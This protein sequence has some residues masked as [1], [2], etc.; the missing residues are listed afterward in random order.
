MARLNP[1]Y[2]KGLTNKQV[3]EQMAK[4]LNYTDVSVPTKS[5]KR[6]VS[7]N[8]FTLFNFL[9]FGLAAAIIA[10]GAYKNCLFIGT[11]IFNIIISI[12]QEIRA[13]QIVDK[14]SLISQS[15]V[16]VIRDG[17]HKDISREEMVQDD[18]VELRVG[19]QVVADSIVMDGTCLVNESFITGEAT[20]IEKKVGDMVL[21]G[22][23]VTGGKVRVKVEHV[24]D[25]N[26][27]SIISKDAKY[28]KKLNSVLMNSLNKIIKGLAIAVVP[29]GIA[30]FIHHYFIVSNNTFN[31][32]V[33][34]T[35]AALI[36][37]IPDGLILL[38]STVLAVSII[39]LSKYKVLVQE[40]YCIETLAR[41]DVLCLDKTGTITEGVM[42]VVDFIPNIK[43]SKDEVED[44]LDGLCHSIEDVSPTMEAVRNRFERKNGK[45]LN[46]LKI[47]PFSSD[48]KYSKVY[49]EGINYYLGAPEFIIKDSN[50]SEYSKDYRTLLLAGEQDNK[51]FPIAL[52]L[53][54]DKIRKEAKDTLKYFK[55]QGVEIKIISGDNPITISQIAK[56]VGIDDYDKYCDLSTIKSKKELKEAY[57]H[58]TIFGRVKPDQ[59]K[60][61]IL[62]I[63]SLGH[64]VA[65]TGDGVNDVL[66]LKEADCS[67]AMA[68]G[69]DAARNVSQ[70]VLMESNFDAMPKVVEEG[71]RC[72]NNIGRSASLF[73]TKT[74]YTILITLMILV[75]A[76]FHT[77][78]HPYL[79]IHLS[80][81]NLITIGAPAFV[82]ALEPN[83][84]R[85][86]G[87]FLVKIFANALPTALTVFTTLLIFFLLSSAANLSKEES[88]TICVIMTTL[89]MFR[90]QYK[91][92]K[93]FNAIRVLLMVSM[94]TIFLCEL[95][96]FKGF[97]SLSK[98]D[99]G[100]YLMIVV[101]VCVAA[102]FWKGYNWLFKYMQ[103][104]SKI[105]R[106][107]MQ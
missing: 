56:R 7:D 107:M 75:S 100:M 25:D 57:L 31:Q 76:L 40:L 14:L 105:F 90:Y 32:A 85:V 55:E 91:L 11:V 47:D 97:F 65:M 103:N 99:T 84:E 39:R 5:I 95:L 62:L 38:T 70:L 82:L 68:S 36:G 9:N 83:K 35:S 3:E 66:A 79:P 89:I 87:N 104:S 67:I 73:L 23:F 37:M 46:Y 27:T 45:E 58:N 81:M 77:L 98:L 50:Y 54:Q 78:E 42:E 74:M 48:K 1:R 10:V 88:S 101:L 15:K 4:G 102:I 17:K 106:K 28:V 26:Y 59:K 94:C 34:E 63:K 12:V 60:E 16:T 49:L 30:L 92:C 71:R 43:Y 61:L 51:K 33:L 29:F 72:I 69:S 8:F 44:I 93:P 6:I 13:K 2:E 21:S 41:V 52:I 80:L 53:I 18:I 22:S 86:K 24:K 64:T 20:P 19:A 96:F